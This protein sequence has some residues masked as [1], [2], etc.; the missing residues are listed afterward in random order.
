MTKSVL[1]LMLTYMVLALAATSRGAENDPPDQP[2]PAGFALVELFTSEGCSSCPPADDVAADIAKRAASLGSPVYVVAYHVDYWD[3]LG[4]KDRFATPDFSARQR[5]YAEETGSK[6]VYTPQMVING[7]V[8]FVGSDHARADQEIKAAIGSSNSKSGAPPATLKLTLDPRVRANL[9]YAVSY[10]VTGIEDPARSG[11]MLHVAVVESGLESKII[12]GENAGKTL[13]H[14][15]VARWFSSSALSDD[16]RGQI[17]V[18]IPGDAAPKHTSIV[19]WLQHGEV[20]PVFAAASLP[21][22]PTKPE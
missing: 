13:H 20:G 19:A 4:W 15:S 18:H 16:A 1:T 5:A 21:L 11:V 22:T 17:L 7:R 6:R 8:E 10:E 3:Y 12:R 14:D 9:R 2:A